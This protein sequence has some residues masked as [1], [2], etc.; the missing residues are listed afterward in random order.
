MVG[1]VGP[2]GKMWMKR[3]FRYRFEEHFF[4]LLP[5]DRSCTGTFLHLS[6][7]TRDRDMLCACT[8]IHLHRPGWH[9][10]SRNCREPFLKK[11]LLIQLPPSS[12]WRLEQLIVGLVSPEGKMWLK[13]P[14]RNPGPDLSCISFACCTMT[15]ALQISIKT[16]QLCRSFTN[17]TSDTS[18]IN[19]LP[20][21]FSS[22]SLCLSV[23]RGGFTQ[24]H[25]DVGSVQH[26][27]VHIIRKSRWEWWC[28]IMGSFNHGFCT[29]IKF[30][31]EILN[32]C[33]SDQ[34]CTGTYFKINKFQPVGRN[35]SKFV[36]YINLPATTL[37]ST[38]SVKSSRRTKLNHC[39][40]AWVEH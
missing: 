8:G 18:F 21:A 17:Q 5:H 10:R 38:Y 40:V 39:N 34:S 26:N 2:E 36:K 4:C 19:L 7:K 12:L 23:T 11:F 6:M 29:K 28:K 30:F 35:R 3:K 15:G 32:W 25:S 33:T 37:P 20:M 14:N 13:P 31:Q 22:S 24:R 27:M 16:T 1:V 9:R